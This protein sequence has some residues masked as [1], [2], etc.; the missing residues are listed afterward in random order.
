MNLAA[1]AKEEAPQ[2]LRFAAVGGAG[3][4]VDAGVLSALHYLAG[5]DPYTAR[6]VSMAVATF[7][8]W[9]LNRMLTFGASHRS[10]AHEGFRYA[11]VAALAAGV[12]YAVYAAA[13][14][15]WRAM[16]P[17]LAVVI[18]SG[19]AMLFS[20]AGYSRLVFADARAV[21]G[22]GGPSSQIR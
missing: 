2:F 20:Y 9:R 13:L 14:L 17:P 15:A 12:N 18:G 1:R 11:V 10:Q 7:A 6:I 3:F 22:S 8:T 19:A 21:A 16:P 5:I 4:A